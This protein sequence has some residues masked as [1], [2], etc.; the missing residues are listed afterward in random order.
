MKAIEYFK[1]YKE[2]LKQPNER[3]SELN[4]KYYCVVS[5]FM[6]FFNEV[7][8]IQLARKAKSDSAMIAIMNEQNLKANSF[9]KM[10]NLEYN[11]GIRIDAFKEFRH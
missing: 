3:D 8:K 9:V 5:S 7:K 11:L 4:H 10:V 1:K 2:K 6:D